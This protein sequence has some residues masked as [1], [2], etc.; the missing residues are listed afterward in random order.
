M[1]PLTE[2]LHLSTQIPRPAREVWAAF[3]DTK[4]RERWS[5][6][7]GE[8]L[9]YTFDEFWTGGSAHYRCGAPGELE[10]FASVTYVAVEAE[11]FVVNTETVWHGDDLLA[12]GLIT[13][14]LADVP[15][16][17][18]VSIS[19]QVVSFVGAEMID[20]NRN[21][22]RIALEQLRAFLSGPG[23][24]GSRASDGDGGSV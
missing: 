7:E 10:F 15:A 21:G 12:T 8:A 2:T 14:S 24:V 17:T 18:S 1:H 23:Q 11:S 22:H 5:V 4:T 19:N 13:W 16:G 9:V 6:P 20:G 3:A